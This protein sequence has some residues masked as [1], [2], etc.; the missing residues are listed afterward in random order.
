MPL[1]RLVIAALFTGL[2]AISLVGCSSFKDDWRQAGNNSAHTT[3]ISGRWEGHW[4]SHVNGH[5][6]KL[7]CVI[8]EMDANQY[9]AKFHATYKMLVN[10][11]F[12]YTVRLHF[13]P[14]A[15]GFAFH[16]EENLGSLAGGVYTYDGQANVTNF[17]CTYASKYDRGAFQLHRPSLNPK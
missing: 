6:D 16:G 14:S 7:R 9:E 15:E 13:K 3:D 4:L 2:S 11:H 10:L 8:T 5:N 17:I 1:R 12:N